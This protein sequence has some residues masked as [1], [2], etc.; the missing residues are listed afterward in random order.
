[1]SYDRTAKDGSAIRKEYREMYPGE[2]IVAITTESDPGR[3][4]INIDPF[5]AVK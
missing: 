5:K 4:D 1:M 3:L 2:V